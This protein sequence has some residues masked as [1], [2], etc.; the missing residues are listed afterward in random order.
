VIDGIVVAAVGTVLGTLLSLAILAA[1]RH[2][3][4]PRR[5]FRLAAESTD[6]ANREVAAD[7]L[8]VLREQ[9]LEVARERGAVLPA[10]ATGHSPTVV[11]Y[12]DGTK[13]YFFTDFAAYQRE[14]TSRRVPPSR[15]FPK[16]PPLPVSR[17]DQVRL[18]Q[19]L[20]QN[21]D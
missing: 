8:G 21:A 7:R 12:S 18:E 5:R 2:R 14:M 11:T 10:T 13:S 16:A 19:W 15:S 17:W 3:S 20:A 6:R 9:V 4:E 1:W